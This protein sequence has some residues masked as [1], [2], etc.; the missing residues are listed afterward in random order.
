MSNTQYAFLERSRVP[1]RDSLQKSIDALGFDLKL[2]PDFSRFEDEG[3]LPFTLA[4]ESGPG[5]EIF[6]QDIAQAIEDEAERAAIA[7]DNDYCISMLWRSSM[8]DLAC[9]MI[10]SCALAKDFG[11]IVSYEGEPPEDVQSMINSTRQIIVDA[12]KERSRARR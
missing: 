8:K 9:V 11:A 6:Y 4:G 12:A 2:D 3:F 5:F 10:V 1:N 7:G